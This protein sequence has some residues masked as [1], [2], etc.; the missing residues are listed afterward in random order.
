MQVM[1][2]IFYPLSGVYTALVFFRPRMLRWKNCNQSRSWFFAIRM[3]LTSLDAPRAVTSAATGKETS[4]PRD[5]RSITN[6]SS[7]DDMVVTEEGGNVVDV[8]GDDSV[9]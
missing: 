1:F 8:E 3:T 4:Q 6:G 9:Q 2:F 7:D 5:D